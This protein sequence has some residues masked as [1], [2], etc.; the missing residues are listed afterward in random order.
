MEKL[1]YKKFGKKYFFQN[2]LFSLPL[3]LLFVI[4]WNRAEELDIIFWTSLTLFI[5]GIIWGFVWDKV[6]RRNFHCPKCNKHILKPTIVN[7]GP[8]DP[9]NYYCENCDV[10]WETGLSVPDSPG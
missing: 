5:S 9:I 4:I 6:R 2:L 3:A 1:E 10:E 8:N 7:A